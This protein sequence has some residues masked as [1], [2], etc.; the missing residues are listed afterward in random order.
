[1]EQRSALSVGEVTLVLPVAHSW[2]A[3]WRCE[4]R[5]ERAVAMILR[6]GERERHVVTCELHD[7]CGPTCGAV[8]TALSVFTNCLCSKVSGQA[9]LGHMLGRWQ[10]CR[11]K[12]CAMRPLEARACNCKRSCVRC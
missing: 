12:V 6:V 5:G 7:A 1:M 8:V 4:S 2:A 10:L 3:G 11:V 9:S